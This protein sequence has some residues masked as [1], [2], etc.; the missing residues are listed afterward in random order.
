MG[1][2]IFN[3]L[4]KNLETAGESLADKRREGFDLKYKLSDALKSALSVF[5]FQYPS[6]LDFQVKMKQK[7]KRDNLETVM[8]VTKIPSNVQVTM[9]LD[10]I[11][12][13]SISG[14]FNENLRAMDEWGGLNEFRCLDGGVL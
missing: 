7:W 9:L 13:E 8:G 10:E 4:V 2:G 14:V 1:R 3:K 6:L 11:S 5:F 12:P